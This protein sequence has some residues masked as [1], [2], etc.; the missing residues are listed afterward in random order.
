MFCAGSKVPREKKEKA[1]NKPE[2][3]DKLDGLISKYRETLF[4]E[5][6]NSQKESQRSSLKRWFE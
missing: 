1:R 5:S 2:K 3:G 6:K 4:G